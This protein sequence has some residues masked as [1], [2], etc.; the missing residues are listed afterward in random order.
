[1]SDGRNRRRQLLVLALA[2]LTVF[3]AAIGAG[4]Y[5][6]G[7]LV[8]FESLGTAED[9]NEIGVIASFPGGPPGNQPGPPGNQPTDGPPPALPGEDSPPTDL[10]GDGLYADLNGDG[11]VD[12]FDVAIMIQSYDSAAVQNHAEHFDFDGDGDVDVYDA[13]ALQEIDVA[14]NDTETA[15][16]SDPGALPGQTEATTDTDGDGL[17]EDTDG[18]GSFTIFDVA[19]L[20]ETYDSDVA[21][22]SPEKFDFDGDGD[23]DIYDAAALMEEV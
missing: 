15:G 14:V 6:F 1:M 2:W 8:D 16:P 7:L 23:V 20:L 9:P 12:V 11:G 21:Q 5:A 19:V 17:H 10:D 3:G 4:G 13:E 22:S 18:D